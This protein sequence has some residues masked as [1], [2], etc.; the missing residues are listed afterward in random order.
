M[1]N[2]GNGGLRERSQTAKMP[3]FQNNNKKNKDMIRERN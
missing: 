3:T 1:E 2:K